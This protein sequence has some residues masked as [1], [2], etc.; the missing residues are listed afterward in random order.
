MGEFLIFNLAI[1]IEKYGRT[2]CGYT[3][4]CRQYSRGHTFNRT[5]RILAVHK[6]P[7]TSSST[8]TDLWH[9]MFQPRPFPAFLLCVLA[10][11]SRESEVV[12]PPRAQFLQAITCD[13]VDI[14]SQITRARYEIGDD[15]AIHIVLVSLFA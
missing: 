6:R 8:H 3:S 9:V 10:G 7:F 14:V 1:S 5:G 11:V 13:A 2:L 12:Y 4:S 15:V